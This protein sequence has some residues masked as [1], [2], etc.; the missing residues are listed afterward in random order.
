VETLRAKTPVFTDESGRRVTAMQWVARGLCALLVL[1]GA[2][3]AIAMV[4]HVPLPGLG[5][6]SPP[7][8]DTAP[9]A[10][11]D[12][13]AGG[14]RALDA[15]L[16]AQSDPASVD[17]SERG[18][19][20]EARAESAVVATDEA[21]QAVTAASTQNV[22]TSEG[23]ASASQESSSGS[24]ETPQP[25]TPAPS[26]SP[27]SPPANSNA[28]PRATAKSANSSAR[29]TPQATTKTKNANATAAQANGQSNR[30]E[31]STPPGQAK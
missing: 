30:A 27:S 5:T 11:R 22:S 3:I 26:A 16:T 23:S 7:L 12:A 20:R 25:Q 17:P 18:N 19:A 28:N 29:A 15:G 2:A 8:S 21:A 14:K 6:L 9:G 31:K 24:A 1:V 13:A 10:A 4:T